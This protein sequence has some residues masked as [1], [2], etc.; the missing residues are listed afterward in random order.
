[1][2]TAVVVCIRYTESHDT[3]TTMNATS[4]KEGSSIVTKTPG[5]LKPLAS[6]CQ[7]MMRNTMKDECS[8]AD[9]G[10]QVDV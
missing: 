3:A 4:T 1:M 5:I 7:M 2:K 9:G 10:K 8:E 6:V